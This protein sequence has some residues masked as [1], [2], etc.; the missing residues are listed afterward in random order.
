MGVQSPDA[1]PPTRG[2]RRKS[3]TRARLL[4]AAR[5]IFARD[6]L[7]AATIAQIT[8]AADVGFGTFYLHFATKDDLYRAVV[9]DGFGE[10]AAL[11][12]AA[13]DEAVARGAPWWEVVQDSVGAYCAFAERNRELFLVMFAGGGA[14]L[15]LGRELQEQFAES[16]AAQLADAAADA[17]ARGLPAPYPYPAQTVAL[18]TVV[19]L[20]RTTLWR[21]TRETLEGAASL[22]FDEHVATLGRYLVAALWGQTPS[23]A[24]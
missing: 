10:L 7:E 22:P 16:L 6:G 14:G 9:T 4:A 1:S 12:D 24:H 18:A 19:A 23:G 13:R 20:T 5:T 21:L 15:G 3:Q 8:S 11:L 17:R 2:A